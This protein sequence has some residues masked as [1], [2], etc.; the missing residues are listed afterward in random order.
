MAMC[1]DHTSVRYCTMLYEFELEARKMA[2]KR[3]RSSGPKT[4]TVKASEA[5]QRFAEL[6]NKVHR[7]EARV[8]IEKSGMPAAVLISAD[9]YRR[10]RWMEQARDEEF[11]A[12]DR[13]ADAFKDEDP[14]E[15]EHEALKA[16]K[17]VR[18]DMVAEG[19]YD[20]YF[21]ELGKERKAKAS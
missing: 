1:E 8:L 11:A 9:D 19:Y 7:G 3:S 18:A 2:E 14:E 21:P 10:F 6:V 4:E 13:I 5:R 15:I 20:K 12:V 16:V 17:E